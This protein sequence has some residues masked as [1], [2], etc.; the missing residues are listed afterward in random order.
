MRFPAK[1]TIQRLSKQ[2][3]RRITMNQ[4]NISQLAQSTLDAYRGRQWLLLLFAS[5]EADAAYREQQKLLEGETEALDDRNLVIGRFFADGE[6]DFAG[7]QT[8]TELP[9]ELRTLFGIAED[10]FAVLLLGKD[11]LLKLHH[12]QVTPPTEFFRVIDQTP[13]YHPA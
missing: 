7:T 2:Q 13:E 4:K 9:G 10:E 11:G 12:R 3:K 8:P 6:S 1:N 5:D